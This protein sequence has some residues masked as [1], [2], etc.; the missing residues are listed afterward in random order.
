MNATLGLVLQD[1]DKCLRTV[2]IHTRVQ[3]SRVLLR[4]ELTAELRHCVEES[5]GESDG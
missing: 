3:P 2:V 1:F 5:N 4:R